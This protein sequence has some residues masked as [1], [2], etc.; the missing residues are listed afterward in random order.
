M[1]ESRCLA[2]RDDGVWHHG[3]VIEVGADHKYQVMFDKSDDVITVDISD[4]VPVDDAANTDSDTSDTS[5]DTDSLHASD[6]DDDNL[7]VYLW[8]PGQCNDVMADWEKHTKVETIRN[9]SH[10]KSTCNCLSPS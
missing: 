5:S 10:S 7:P 3:T 9:Q 4:V 1:L 8:R 6:D 2:K